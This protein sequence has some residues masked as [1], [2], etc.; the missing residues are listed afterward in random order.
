MKRIMCYLCE[1]LIREHVKTV[2]KD[3]VEYNYHAYCYAGL[4]AK[5]RKH[6]Q[7]LGHKYV[8]STP[9]RKFVAPLKFR[10]TL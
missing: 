5:A 2:V 7:E 8:T 4:I 1:R 10:I 9:L 6:E 3:G